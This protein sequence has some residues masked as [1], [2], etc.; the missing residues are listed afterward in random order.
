[1]SKI[2]LGLKSPPIV[3]AVLDIECD[4]APGQSVVGLKEA[5]TAK[6]S[7]RYPKLHTLFAQQL[8]LELGADKRIEN[9]AQVPS[10]VAFQFLQDDEKQLIQLREK[11]YA[12]NRL[13]PYSS[14]DDYL[15]EIRRTWDIYRDLATP[16]LIRVVRLRYINRLDL[17]F[18]SHKLDLDS[19]FTAGPRI[20]DE[21]RLALWGFLNQHQLVE[22]ETGHHITTVLAA[23]KAEGDKLPV[24]FDNTVAAEIDADPIDWQTLEATIQSLR[25]LKNRVFADT[26]TEKCLS[27]FQ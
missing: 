12:F 1:M 17:P 18:A 26:L 3:E 27:L 5:A 25:N 15:P 23:G 9:D 10:V 13:A 21:D 8:T 2:T 14:L 22:E 24:I 4:F 6:F 20:P 7:A 19:Y 11:G 16:I